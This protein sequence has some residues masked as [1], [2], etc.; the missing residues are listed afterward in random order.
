M[1]VLGAGPGETKLRCLD[2]VVGVAR[3]RFRQRKA[4]EARG[5]LDEAVTFWD[6]GLERR[7]PPWLRILNSMASPYIQM[8]ERAKRRGATSI[9][10]PW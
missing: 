7:T 6:R 10:N 4:R 5:L 3:S 8:G 2:S 1:E 9:A